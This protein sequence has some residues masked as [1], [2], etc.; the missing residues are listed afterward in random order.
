MISYSYSIERFCI[1]DFTQIE[2]NLNYHFIICCFFVGHVTKRIFLKFEGIK[3]RCDN[4]AKWIMYN[5][6][7]QHPS[8]VF[9][10]FLGPGYEIRFAVNA[11]YSSVEII[12]ILTVFSATVWKFRCCPW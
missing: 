3:T 7:G 8:S 10:L 9:V 1:N 2:I 12:Y 5:F 6:I 4:S 11:L